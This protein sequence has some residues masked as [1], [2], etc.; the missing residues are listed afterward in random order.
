MQS[1]QSFFLVITGT[2]MNEFQQVLLLL[3]L[4]PLLAVW[5]HSLPPVHIGCQTIYFRRFSQFLA[6]FW[7]IN[8]LCRYFTALR[9]DIITLTHC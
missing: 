4:F 7:E 1:F 8:G 6:D 9:V 2:P 5:G 3:Q